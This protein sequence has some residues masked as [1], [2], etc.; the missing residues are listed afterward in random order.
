[1]YAIINNRATIKAGGTGN[2][3]KLART[4]SKREANPHPGALSPPERRLWRECNYRGRGKHYR[5]AISGISETE[6]RSGSYGTTANQCTEL[7]WLSCQALRLVEYTTE[8]PK[9]RKK[10]VAIFFD[11]AKAFDKYT[12]LPP[13]AIN[14]L[15]QWFL[16]WRIEVNPDKSAATYFKRRKGKSVRLVP[17][18]VSYEAPPPYHLIRRPRNALTDPLDALTVEIKRLNKIN[19]QNLMFSL[20]TFLVDFSPTLPAR[21][22]AWVRVTHFLPPSG[23]RREKQC[24][25]RSCTPNAICEAHAAI[26]KSEH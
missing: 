3:V 16:T 7:M 24:I 1:M 2:S 22:G 23:H 21:T 15:A 19:K 12:P 13:K 5:P 18:A 14:E 8:G 11:V 6:N 4:F 10:T 9:T 25:R 17:Q 26:N 20:G